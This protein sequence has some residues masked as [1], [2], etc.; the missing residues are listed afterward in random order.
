MKIHKIYILYTGVFCKIGVTKRNVSDR[1]KEIQTSCPIPIHK[2]VEISGLDKGTAYHI[3]NEM[4]KHLSDHLVFGEWYKEFHGIEKSIKF[5]LSEIGTIYKCLDFNTKNNKFQDLSI[6]ILN[7]I[8]NFSK[9]NDIS[10]L[11]SLSNNIKF[12]KKDYSDNRFLMYSKKSVLIHLKNTIDSTIRRLS[13]TKIIDNNIL[14]TIGFDEKSDISLYQQSVNYY[15]SKQNFK[16]SDLNDNEYLTIENKIL[17]T[18]LDE[19]ESNHRKTR[20]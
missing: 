14:K 7:N 5:K 19:I 9:E 11:S 18:I 3:E 12:N 17:K 4:K 13:K 15:L 10:S 6:R 20:T 8:K 2:F 16:R 1:L